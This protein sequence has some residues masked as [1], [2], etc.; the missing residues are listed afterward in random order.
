MLKESDRNEIARLTEEY[1]GK[2]GVNHTQRLLQ[3]VSLIDEGQKYDPEV[4]WIAAY[5]HDW[6]AYPEWAQEGVDHAARSAEIAGPFLRDRGLPENEINLIVECIATH[7]SGAPDRSIEAILLS[8]ADGLDFLG[9]VGI[10]RDFAKK[11]KDMRNAY[12]AARKRQRDVPKKLCLETT[13]K[14]GA[15]R[16][17]EMDE[18]LARFESET[19]GCY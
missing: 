9:V 17:R 2:W 1:G 8:D 10:M 16:A 7:H 14:I 15:E 11:P 6:G 18:I 12:E 13:K 4:V 19:F 3:L 5:L